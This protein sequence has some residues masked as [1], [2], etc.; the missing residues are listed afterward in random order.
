M[1]PSLRQASEDLWPDS[2]SAS[3]RTPWAL[4]S[5]PGLLFQR[6][7]FGSGNQP[8]LSLPTPHTQ[9]FPF[10]KCL[11]FP[12]PLLMSPS[13]NPDL[14][15]ADLLPITLASWL[16]PPFILKPCPVARSPAPRCV[17][18]PDICAFCFVGKHGTSSNDA[19]VGHVLFC[20]VF[21]SDAFLNPSPFSFTFCPRVFYRFRA[22]LTSASL[23]CH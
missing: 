1:L 6:Q 19:S 22:F 16:V 18:A 7:R 17:I 5:V 12:W 4:P 14:S 9:S 11:K 10:K 20:F 13:P 15:A 2:V 8:F 21:Y 23:P 3:A